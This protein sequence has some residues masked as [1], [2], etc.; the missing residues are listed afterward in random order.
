MEE[1][2]LGPSAPGSVVLDL[3][4]GQ[5]A[6]VLRTPPEL[7]GV[8]IEISRQDLPESRRVHSQVRPRHLASGP[9]YAAVYPGLAVGDYAV[10]R[11]ETTSAMVVTVAAATV[12]TTWWPPP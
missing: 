7:D 4:P 6:L 3:G 2:T 9:Q 11:D 12:T 5:G 10:W 8:E 1:P